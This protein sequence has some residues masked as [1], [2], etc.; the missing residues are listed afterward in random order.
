MSS[1]N[2]RRSK[3]STTPLASAACCFSNNDTRAVAR[4]DDDLRGASLALGELDFLEID[5]RSCLRFLVVLNRLSQKLRAGIIVTVANDENDEAAQIGRVCR[6][7]LPPDLERR[8][9]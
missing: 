7:G 1:L 4:L 2:S 5:L 8:G 9:R 3:I 6:V